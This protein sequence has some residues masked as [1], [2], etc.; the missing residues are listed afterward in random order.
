MKRKRLYIIDE[1]MESCRLMPT[2]VQSLFF[3]IMMGIAMLI[4]PVIS[5]SFLGV[6]IVVQAIIIILLIKKNIVYRSISK[7]EIAVRK[8]VIWIH[9]KKDEHERIKKGLV[10]LILILITAYLFYIIQDF[11]LLLINGLFCLLFF[12]KFAFYVPLVSVRIIKENKIPFQ[13]CIIDKG[14]QVN[15]EIGLN[16]IISV[17]VKLKMI[18]VITNQEKIDVPIDFHSDREARRLREFLKRLNMFEVN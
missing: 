1:L 10:N 15:V 16:E 9:T 13:L 8:M 4:V 18:I 11:K 12:L 6:V 14:E 2:W 5:Y 17:V 7:L 3:S